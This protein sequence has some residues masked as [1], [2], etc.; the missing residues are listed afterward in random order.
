MAQNQNKEPFHF[1][2]GKAGE[3][4]AAC[5][6]EKKG[7]RVL[8]KNYRCQLGEIDLVLEKDRRIIFAEVKTR[9]SLEKGHPKEAVDE[10]K[11]MQMGKT[12]AWYLKNHQMADASV[13]FDVV[14]VL[15]DRRGGYEIEHVENAL[16]FD[17]DFLSKA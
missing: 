14:S 8:E 7:Y 16:N 11:R 1:S 5:S 10:R 15:L 9:S 17:R 4:W 2:L 12:A 3:N 13:R 6:L